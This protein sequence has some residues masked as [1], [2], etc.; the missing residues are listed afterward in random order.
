MVSLDNL[1]QMGDFLVSHTWGLDVKNPKLSSGLSE[2]LNFTCQTVETI[3]TNSKL[4]HILYFIDT[5]DCKTYS[6]IREILASKNTTTIDLYTV[7][8]ADTITFVEVINLADFDYAFERS[9]SSA[10]S[11]LVICKLTLTNKLN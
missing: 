11:S 9:L 1:K 5:V 7:D 6:S 8:R 4:E 3:I 10:D 2:R